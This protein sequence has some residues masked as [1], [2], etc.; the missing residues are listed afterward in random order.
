MPQ[1]YTE[2]THVYHDL[3][4]RFDLTLEEYHVLEKAVK[5]N[6]LTYNCLEELDYT[7]RMFEEVIDRLERKR[8]VNVSSYAITCPQNVEKVWRSYYQQRKKKKCQRRVTKIERL[9]RVTS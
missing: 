7:D 4:K 3:M 8:L 6:G 5:N 1:Q 9:P 2:T